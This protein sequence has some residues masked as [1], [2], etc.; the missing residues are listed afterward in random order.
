VVDFIPPIR[1]L[2]L[3]LWSVYNTYTYVLYSYAA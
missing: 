3:G 1:D 2:E